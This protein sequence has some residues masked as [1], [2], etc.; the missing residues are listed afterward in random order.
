MDLMRC[1]HKKELGKRK[2][3]AKKY[4]CGKHCFWSI[5]MLFHRV[6]RHL[7]SVIQKIVCFE[8]SKGLKNPS[9]KLPG[10]I[11][12]KIYVIF[13]LCILFFTL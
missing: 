10:L 4:T 6:W 11:I 9:K 1:L 5:D 7:L 12:L 2:A 3:Y 8:S 13:T